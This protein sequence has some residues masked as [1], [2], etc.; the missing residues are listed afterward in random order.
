MLTFI[1]VFAYF[2]RKM[3]R[4]QN[5]VIEHHTNTLRSNTYK[6]AKFGGLDTK[7]LDLVQDPIMICA[8]NQ[9]L[10]S[11]KAFLNRIS[12]RNILDKKIFSLHINQFFSREK[13]KFITLK[14]VIKRN[15]PEEV[16][17][18]QTSQSD[19]PLHVCVKSQPIGEQKS[20]D[21]L[22]L[23]QVSIFPEKVIFSESNAMKLF[24]NII[25]SV[26][27]H[28]LRNPLNSLVA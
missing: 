6:V 23:I 4:K 16:Y 25:N 22:T 27:C 18:L 12:K 13:L 26:I 7:T 17:V 21:Q 20:E 19:Q 8:Q 14:D 10:F 15:K 11:N 1:Q 2:M 24:F 28:E 3:I 9:P 5:L